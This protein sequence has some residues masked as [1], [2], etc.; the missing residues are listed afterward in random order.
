MHTRRQ[1]FVLHNKKW[2]NSRENQSNLGKLL[3]PNT[4]FPINHEHLPS[5][6]YNVLYSQKAADKVGNTICTY[7]VPHRPIPPYRTWN[8]QPAHQAPAFWE[9]GWFKNKVAFKGRTDTLRGPLRY[10]WEAGKKIC[11]KP[12]NVR[13]KR[14]NW[15][16][17][18]C[19]KNNTI[20]MY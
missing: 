9:N 20:C 14:T 5:A 12:Q 19:K 11:Y 16:A 1:N 6:K 4:I 8:W 13:H 15:L 18:F 3:I 17:A 10:V 2:R 7:P